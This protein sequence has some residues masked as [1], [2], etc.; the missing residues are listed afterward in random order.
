MR[1][2]ASALKVEAMSLYKHIA[3]KEELLDGLVDLVIAQ[4]DVPVLSAG[5]VSRWKEAM[6]ERAR[7][8][9]LQFKA[10]PWAI[11]LF[12]SRKRL[13]AVRIQ[14]A[15]RVLAILRQAGFSV[16]MAYR[17][18]L[19]LDSYIYGFLVQ[20]LNWSVTEEQLPDFARSMVPLLQKAPY[21]TEVMEQAMH[22]ASTDAFTEE[23]EFGMQLILDQLDRY[24][25]R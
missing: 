12:E 10:H 19:L 6:A 24:R 21:L 3:D 22:T 9:R 13:S 8:A 1:R 23:F 25:S 4:I 20:E 16:V 14:Y 11:A 18:F 5:E 17:A 2:L 7:S 15:E